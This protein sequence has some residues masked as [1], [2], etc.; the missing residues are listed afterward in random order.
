MEKNVIKIEI[1]GLARACL[2][3]TSCCFPNYDAR[4]AFEGP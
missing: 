3:S 2:A 4:D 1:Y